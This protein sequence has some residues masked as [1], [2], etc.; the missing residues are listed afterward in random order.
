[1]IHINTPAIAARPHPEPL[2]D[3]EPWTGSRVDLFRD[4]RTFQSGRPKLRDVHTNMCMAGWLPRGQTF[5]AHG[6]YMAPDL[7]GAPPADRPRLVEVVEQIRGDCSVSLMFGCTPFVTTPAEAVL[8][9]LLVEDAATDP[10]SGKYRGVV[11]VLYDAA[12]AARDGRADVDLRLREARAAVDALLR[13]VAG[14]DEPEA[15]KIARA[16]GRVGDGPKCFPHDPRWISQHMRDFFPLGIAGAP[17]LI[18]EQKDFYLRLVPEQPAPGAEPTLLLRA[19]I[20][21]VLLKG[22]QG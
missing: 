16:I 21:G 11:S 4:H 15:Q 20:V 5:Y 2:Y 12:M 3:A 19:Y 13:V 17:L 7:R 10:T 1:M 14:A 6:L 18:T 9:N 22:I 8:S